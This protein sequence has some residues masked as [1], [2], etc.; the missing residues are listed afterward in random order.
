MREKMFSGEKINFTLV[1]MHWHN[2]ELWI[3]IFTKLYTV[4]YCL[5]LVVGL[6]R[7][8]THSVLS[9]YRLSFGEVIEC[10]N[11]PNQHNDTNFLCV[12]IS[13]YDN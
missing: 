1:R 8:L 5:Q 3:F 7:P 9:T 6:A 4:K 11:S 13:E 10:Q 12:Q 2:I